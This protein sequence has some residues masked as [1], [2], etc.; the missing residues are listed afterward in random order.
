MTATKLKGNGVVPWCEVNDIMPVFMRW[1]DL[2]KVPNV[3]AV[4]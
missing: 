2:E 4:G 3:R 1:K